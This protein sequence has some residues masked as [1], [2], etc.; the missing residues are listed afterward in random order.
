M[1]EFPSHLEYTGIYRFVELLTTRM[2]C[3]IPSY[4]CRYLNNPEAMGGA[5]WFGLALIS[6]SKLVLSLAVLRH[7]VNW[8]FLTSVEKYVHDLLSST[9]G[10]P[11]AISHC[12]P[13]MRKLYGESLRQDAGFVKVIKNVAS[14]NA[15]MLESRADRHVPELKRVVTEVKGTFDKVFEETAEALEE[16]LAKCKSRTEGAH[17]RN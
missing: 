6:G 3:L 17:D 12:S 2:Q 11:N 4:H 7:L 14:K 15:K 1:E 13:H 16:F 8:W 10:C 9:D 5:A